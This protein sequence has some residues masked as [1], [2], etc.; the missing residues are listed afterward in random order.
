[1]IAAV[2]SWLVS[3]LKEIESW[4][5]TGLRSE[6]G[7]S[8]LRIIL[9]ATLL[10]QLLVNFP[11][12]N[13]LWGPAS[14]W[15]QNLHATAEFPGQ[16]LLF[17]PTSD[18]T[19]MTVGYC[20]L[21]VATV[22]FLLG[23]QT[24]LATIVVLILHT[25]MTFSDG[26]YMDQSDNFLRMALLYCVF[27]RTAEHWSLDA[28]RAQ[29]KASLKAGESV[30]EPYTR[31]LHNVSIT[32]FGAHICMIYVASAMFKTQGS[33]WQHGTGLY[34]P[35]NV[36]HFNPW[37]ELSSIV[38][39]NALGIMVG[40]Y[41][42]VYLQLFFPFML[43]NKYLRK[44][45]LLGI[46]A[47]HLGIAVLMGLPFFSFFMLAGDSIFVSSKTYKAVDTWVRKKARSFRKDKKGS[48]SPLSKEETVLEPVA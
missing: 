28:R 48:Q 16:R 38:E 30:F 46:V 26:V 22:A 39:Q 27:M 24:R 47:M 34:Y 2:K 32:G 44:I 21:V 35:L 17:G 40:T 19:I 25:W 45:A 33:F 23:W 20:V 11:V 1:M 4:F 13:Y 18:L 36:P 31:L 6:W 9:G 14:A 7:A 10:V 8:F 12:R 41:A 43:L 42:A 3:T 37:P 15:S 29:K 5:T